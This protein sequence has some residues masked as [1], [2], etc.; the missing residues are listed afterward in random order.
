MGINLP[1][2]RFGFRLLPLEREQ[3]E[4]ASVNPGF[5][6]RRGLYGGCRT[7]VLSAVAVVG[8]PQYPHTPLSSYKSLVPRPL[9]P[10]LR[11]S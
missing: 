11:S 7:L 1:P 5:T 2:I 8:P 6:F 3:C 4:R 9:Q 10:S